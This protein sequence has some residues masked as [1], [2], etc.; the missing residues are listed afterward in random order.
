LFAKALKL[1][2][3]IDSAYLATKVAAAITASPIPRISQKFKVNVLVK[4]IMQKLDTVFIRIA[5]AS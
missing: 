2:E 5:L 1:V 4:I 3:T